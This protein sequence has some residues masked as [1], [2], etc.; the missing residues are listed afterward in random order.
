MKSEPFV[1]GLD[2]GT[3]KICTIV[4]QWDEENSSEKFPR[5]KILGVGRAPSTGVKKGVVVNIE[6]TV[7]CIRQAVQEAEVS[8]G[9][10]INRASV[11]IAGGHI[12][13]FNSSG[14]VGIKGREVSDYDISRVIDA[15]RA[16]AIP[17]DRMALHVLAQEYR[18]DEQGGIRDP[19]GMAGTRLEAK[20]HI[21]TAASSAIQ[22]IARCC[23]KAGVHVSEF[24]LQPL[25]SAK[26]VLSEDERDLGVALVD[27]G[28]GTTDLAI[29][30]GGSIVHTAVIPLGGCHITQDLA[31][32]LRTPQSEAEKIKVKKGK[33]L[34]AMLGTDHSLE[35]PGVGGRPARVVEQKILGDIIEPR[36]E[37]M[38]K[39]VNYEIVQ[40]GLTDILGGGVVI[41]GG[42]TQ[43]PGML[44]LAEYIFDLPV[45]RAHPEF[46]GM[47]AEKVASPG[48][49]TGVGLVLWA[50]EN[51]RS[52]KRRQQQWYTVEGFRK[53]TRQ[54][55]TWFEELF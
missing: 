47:G 42:C 12:K 20:A 37:E 24:I 36:V 55:K 54:V 43:L 40:R 41:T 35:V 2:F 11:G 23:Q 39:L 21:V 5:I 15:A 18:V 7:E 3:T 19:L 53:I 17:S 51:S 46:L 26:A 4:G 49:S 44:E 16:V 25:A 14:V 34:K 6:E 28:G 50:L 32:G 27:V 13:G 30:H 8:A 48:Y 52:G 29:F 9:V 45:K 1:A 22:N 10:K 38:F 33:A 31:V